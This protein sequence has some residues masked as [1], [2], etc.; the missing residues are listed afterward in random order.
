MV[1]PQSILA[2]VDR[3]QNDH[4]AYRSNVYNETQVRREFVDPFFKALGWDIDNEGGVPVAQRHV[5]HEDSL[6]IGEATKAP[7]YSF[8]IGGNRNFFVEAKKPSVNLGTDPRPAYQLRR[9]A[10]SASLPLS[11]LT[12]FE[13]FVVYDGRI[14]PEPDDLAPVARTLYLKFTDYSDKW[15][16]IAALFS[17]QAV[18]AG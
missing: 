17:R 1:V 18:L 7:D 2:L 9:Y 16:D 15:E 6:K 14:R 10:W 5:I 4:H 13:E 3:F 11:V 8:R 12:N